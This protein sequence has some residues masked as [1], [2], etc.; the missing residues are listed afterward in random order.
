MTVEWVHPGLVLIVGAW[1]LP[2]LKG[3]LKRVVMVGLPSA[4]L[5]RSESRASW[6]NMR[7]SIAS[8]ISSR[9]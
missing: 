3:R 8:D 7:R 2:F 1:L 6:A 4:A 5:V 9:Y